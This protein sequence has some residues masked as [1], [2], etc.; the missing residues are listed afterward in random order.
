MARCDGTEALGDACYIYRKIPVSTGWFEPNVAP[1]LSPLAFKP[2]QGDDSGLSFDRARYRTIEEAA[3]GKSLQGYY[4]A[5]LR[6]GELRARNI[7]V[8]SRPVEG[9]PGH[10]EM[11][12]LTYAN[13][14]T[15]QAKELMV[16]LA[17]EFTLRVEG[18]FR[19]VN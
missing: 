11:P 18:P 13:R 1:P 19:N 8:V 7:D 2:R 12:A 17:H 10:A 16:R 9:N 14:K 6:V 15:D 3:Q 4:V 5:V